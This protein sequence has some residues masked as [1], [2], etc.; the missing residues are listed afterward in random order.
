[1][2]DKAPT[3]EPLSVGLVGLGYWGPN[4]LRVLSEADGVEIRYLC[5][6]DAARLEGFARRAPQARLTTEFEDL[7]ADS[8]L[9]AILLSTPV[10]SHHPLAA[11][12][13]A[14]G[15][16]TFV[17]KPLAASSDDAADLVDEAL[18]R[19]LVLMCG[20]TFLHS[21]AVQAVKGLL[22]DGELGS[23][24]FISSSRVNLGIHQRDVGILWDL[25]P[26]DFSIL[27]H[28]M[29]AAPESVR[30]VGRASII[31]GLHDV[32]FIDVMFPD[33]LLA[34]AELS[35]LAPS[36]LRR[37]VIVGRDRMVVY[38]DGS[39]EPLRI[40][41][42]GVVYRDPETFGE[43]H[44]SYRTGAI[45]SPTL[46]SVEPLA[47]EVDE[48]LEAVRRGKPLDENMALSRNVVALIEAAELSLERGGETVPFSSPVLA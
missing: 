31:D 1:M 42:H 41:D 20:H 7:T 36:K 21:P 43:Y 47:V 9:D 17:E 4:L 6:L 27:L 40:F 33:G 11:A 46:A 14:A 18:R 8:D 16:A 23:L 44:L 25:G 5:D 26:H 39:P 2:S 32:A 38:E 15:K 48:F 10:A 12:S 29:D 34:H 30:A 37:T 13:L 28:W 22:D 35:W 3:P 24:C 19:G 45:V